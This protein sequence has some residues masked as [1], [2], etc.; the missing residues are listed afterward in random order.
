MIDTDLKEHQ[1]PLLLAF[2]L[3]TFFSKCQ[4]TE[5]PLNEHMD[6]SNQSEVVAA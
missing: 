4:E 3:A 5:V 6:V 1:S 2:V